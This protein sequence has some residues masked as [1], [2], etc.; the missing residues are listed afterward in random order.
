MAATDALERLV[1]GRAEQYSTRVAFFITGLATAAW[2]PLVPFAKLRAGLN[3]G[4]LGLL[5]LCLGLGSIIAMPLAGALATRFGCR[6]MLVCATLV[7]CASLPWLAALS[8][9]PWLML[10]LFAFGAGVGS[11]D[12]VINVQ[13]VIVERASAKTLMSG[14]HGLFSLGGIAGAGGVSLMLSLGMSPW[15]TT[16]VIGAISL[17]AVYCA[18]PYLLPYGAASEGPAFAIPRGIV[19]F[20]GLLCFIVFLTEGAMLDWSAVFLSAD[21]GMSPAHAGLGYAVFALA[22]TIARLGGD[23]VVARLGRR[24][25]VA[26]GGLCASAGLALITL[27][28]GW[29]LALFAHLLVGFGCANIVPVMYSLVGKQRVMP[30]SVAIPAITTVGYAGI[31]LGP[32][33]IGFAAHAASLA[34]ALLAVAVALLGVAISAR[35]LKG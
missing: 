7:V 12:C 25:V 4:T 2:A 32:A 29:E 23:V 14:F 19:L 33:L 10:A 20:I 3:E 34:A 26:C 6:R 1:P 22:M 5:L 24:L 15:G 9:L 21:K 8:S 16:L 31:L 30:E 17:L 28:P 11:L 13:A 35:L 18:A 27:A